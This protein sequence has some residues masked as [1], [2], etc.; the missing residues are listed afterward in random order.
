MSCEDIPEYDICRKRGDTYAQ[1]F[2]FL[3]DG[4]GH[5]ITGDTLELAVNSEENPTDTTNQLFLMTTSGGSPEL[6]ILG[7]ADGT[8]TV[9]PNATNAD[10][11]PATYYYDL[12]WTDTVGT[13]EKRTIMRGKWI[14]VQDITKA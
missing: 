6:V 9:A 4:T 1:T 10:Q 12:Q 2:Q 5:D 14:V 7:S 11:T 3:V 8:F 13:G